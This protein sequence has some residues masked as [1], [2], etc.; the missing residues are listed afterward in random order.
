MCSGSLSCSRGANFLTVKQI[1]TAK[2][3]LRSFR[4]GVR[5]KRV[6]SPLQLPACPTPCIHTLTKFLAQAQFEPQPFHKHAHLTTMLEVCVLCVCVGQR[7]ISWSIPGVCFCF[8][9]TCQQDRQQ[10]INTETG[11]IANSNRCHTAQQ[12]SKQKG[13]LYTPGPLLS[14]GH[15]TTPG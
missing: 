5:T 9:R 4:G 14:Q 1:L 15:A 3:S 13:H 6:L 12:S 8:L 10:H 7:E 2:I 11:G